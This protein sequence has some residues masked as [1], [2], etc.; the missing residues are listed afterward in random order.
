MICLGFIAI[1]LFNQS[2]AQ[3]TSVQDSLPTIA[4]EEVKIAGLRANESQPFAYANVDKE[5][6]ASRNLVDFDIVDVRTIDPVNLLRFEKVIMSVEAV[7]KLEEL[8]K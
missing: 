2:H 5:D 7:S 8:L 4:L 3:T 1:I 6:L